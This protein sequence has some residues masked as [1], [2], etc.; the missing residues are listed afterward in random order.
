VIVLVEGAVGALVDVRSGQDPIQNLDFNKAEAETC[1][2]FVS[3]LVKEI[4]AP[5]VVRDVLKEFLRGFTDLEFNWMLDMPTSLLA[6]VTELY[7]V[8]CVNSMIQAYRD[9]STSRVADTSSV[10]IRDFVFWAIFAS[11]A[12]R[13]GMG[14]LPAVSRILRWSHELKEIR[15][16]EELEKWI[17]GAGW[18]LG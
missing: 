16:K 9:R 1:L 5:L 10:V 11:I 18:D 2:I 15:K 6:K 13:R 3:Q 8:P 12:E 14:D 17:D 7:S 4:K